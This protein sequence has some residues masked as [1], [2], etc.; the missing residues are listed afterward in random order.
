MDYV[1]L[2]IGADC[3]EST[4]YYLGDP[5]ILGTE[6]RR[7]TVISNDVRDTVQAILPSLMRVFLGADRTVESVPQGPEDAQ[8][9]E[10]ATD[11][12]NHILQTDNDDLLTLHSAF[13]DALVKKV[14]I[15]KVLW[16]EVEKTSP[17]SYTGV[18]AKTLDLLQ[19]D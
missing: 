2:E 8:V 19:M 9:A 5:A 18:D 13:K 14:G 7:S 15:I 1:D 16:N 17:H 12:I 10:K 6:D 3:A 4:K 11:Y